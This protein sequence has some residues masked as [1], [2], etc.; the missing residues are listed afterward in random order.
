M[1]FSP[2][3]VNEI[4]L[5]RQPEHWWMIHSGERLHV[6][7]TLRGKKSAKN[8]ANYSRANSY[9]SSGVSEET[10]GGWWSLIEN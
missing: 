2:Q 4:L 7:N 8:L 6:K 9:R 10:E 3:T 5:V 1:F